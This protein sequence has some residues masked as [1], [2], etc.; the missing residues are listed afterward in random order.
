MVGPELTIC[1]E[2]VL[3][4]PQDRKPPRMNEVRGGL[5]I[6]TTQEALTF[7]LKGIDDNL[8]TWNAH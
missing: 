7:Y 2:S 6:I 1:K 3:E 5:E 8:G 4:Q